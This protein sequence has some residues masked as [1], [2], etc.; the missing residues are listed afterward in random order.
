MVFNPQD[1]A[2]LG[3]HIRLDVLRSPE[4]A[5]DDYYNET[6]MGNKH[7]LLSPWIGQV[8]EPSQVPI[9]AKEATLA[10]VDQVW[11]AN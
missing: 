6:Y 5:G 11:S 9:L 2:D 3:V 1:T 7:T 10:G 8:N 4:S